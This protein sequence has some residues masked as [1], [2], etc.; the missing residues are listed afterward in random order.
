MPNHVVNELIFRHLSDAEK[1]GLHP[2]LVN[3]DGRVDFSILLPPPL[4]A[5]PGS[6]GTRHEQAF[7]LTQAEWASQN[8]GTE[9]NAYSCKPPILDDG[10]ITLIF[11]TAWRPPYGW[12]IA[13]FNR[14][15]LSFEHNWL[16][17]GRER[18]VSG[19]FHYGDPDGWDQRLE[20]DPWREEEVTGEM[21]KHLHFLRWGV[22]A[23]EEEEPS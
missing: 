3:A 5:W 13:I 1:A 10:S 18:G 14:F 15:K 8:W 6:V 4:N 17:E 12:L 9:R 2:N 23:F 19:R 20:F 22:E 21:Q 11:Q 16:D 7:K